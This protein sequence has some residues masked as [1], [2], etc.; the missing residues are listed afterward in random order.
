MPNE[1]VDELILS[2]HCLVKHCRFGALKKKVIKD[3][4]VAGLA[5]V[6]LFE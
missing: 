3:C 5:D 4:L 6:A 2:L 1:P